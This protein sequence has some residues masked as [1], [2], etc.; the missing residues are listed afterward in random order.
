MP[1]DTEL[2]KAAGKGSLSEV[3]DFLEKVDSGEKEKVVNT[4]GSQGRTAIMRACSAQSM[5]VFL[6]LLKCGASCQIADAHGRSV[7]HFAAI[8]NAVEILQYLVENKVDADINLLTNK[9]SSCLHSAVSSNSA[10]AIEFLLDGTSIDV[11]L[12]NEDGMTAYELAENK[13]LSAV[14]ALFKRKGLGSNKSAAC[15]I[16]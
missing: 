13:K 8:S 5:E 14:T 11:S 2:H 10:E 4:I 9:G 1:K 15:S 3:E 12:T 6:C 16:L 7:Y